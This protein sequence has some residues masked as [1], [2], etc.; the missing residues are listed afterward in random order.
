MQSSLSFLQFVPLAARPSRP[1][2]ARAPRRGPRARP[3]T[4]L[5]LLCSALAGSTCA[6]AGAHAQPATPS[7]TAKAASA[8]PPRNPAKALE[9][10]KELLH[11]SNYADAEANLRAALVGKHRAEAETRLAE[12]L[13]LTGRYDDALKAAKS[14]AKDKQFKAEATTYGAKALRHEGKLDEALALLE[15][16]EKEPE[17]RAARL[18]QGEIL[19][20]KGKRSEAEAP[21][22]TLIE[23][24][25]SD[26][27][28]ETD[29]AGLA[30]V[31]RAAHLLRAPQDANDAFNQ[32]ERAKTG[33]I[34]TLLW[35]AE[36]FL[37]KYDPGHAEEVIKEVLQQAPNHPEALVWMAHVKLA[38]ALDFDAAVRLVNQ[39]L[40]VNPKLGNAHFVLAGINLRDME[41][42]DADK[43]LDDGLK[44]NPRD[45]DLL[46]L[47]AAVRFL[48]DDDAGFQKA[49]RR[50]LKLN[51]QYSRMYQIIGE[52]A[53]WE[54]R[55]DEI[56][57][58]MR[59]ALKI[60]S[61]DAKAEAQ[62]GLNLI[63]AGDDAAG[64]K[65]LQSAFD[66]DGF[67]VRVY[68]TL[69]LYEKTI[70][71]EYVTV[72]E[73][74]Y[75]FRYHKDERAILE[76][77]IPGLM[78]DAWKAMVKYYGFTPS[79]PIGVELYADR[80]DFAIRTSGLPGTAIQGVCFGKTLASMSPKNETF[81]VGMTVWHELAHVFH[82]QMSKSHVPR[83]FTEGMAEYET[84]VAR[85]EWQREQDQDLYSA[86][87]DDRLP[88]LGNMNKAFTRA[89]E[90]SDIA[91]AYYASSQI[92][93][94]LG[95]KYGRAKLNQM[96]ELW[97]E[98]K[99][100]PEVLK[101]AL[102]KD[103]TELDRE[104][105]AFTSKLLGRYKKQFMPI[106]RT[107]PFEA[108]EE[109]ATKDPKSA[110]AQTTYAL[111]L[112][113]HGKAKQ[114]E[115]TLAAALKI[116]PKFPDAIYI[117]ARIAMAKR[118]AR[119]AK[120]LLEQL[121]ADGNDGY[122]VRMALADLAEGTGDVA[123]MKAELQ[124]AHRLDP[125]MAE[126][127]QALVDLAS[128]QKDHAAELDALKK[129]AKL[130]QHDPRVY[131][132]LMERL[133]EK[134]QLAEARAAGEAATWAD[135]EGMDTHRVFGEV[136][137]ASK[138]VPRAI[139]EGQSALLCPG[140]PKDQAKVHDLL[141]RAYAAVPNPKQ[142]AKHRKLAKSVL[143]EAS[144]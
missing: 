71:T 13:V 7:K 125:S 140:R 116:D 45:L 91:T 128:K 50:V 46:S 51:P 18:L 63:R 29:A 108:A 106:T 112:L 107:G 58:M 60:D 138:M 109:A 59:E 65:A 8:K 134:K 77:Y 73:G 27:I 40:K 142:A 21:L 2:V 69:N 95:E 67:N 28:T 132:R 86:L 97:G 23:D 93:V 17:A 87:R 14:A 72:K 110:K 34:Q 76:R 42:A 118:D 52:Y 22:M 64:L 111:A 56:V 38:Q 113:R 57:A 39:A 61:E 35:R 54:H 26:K 82:I 99:R 48:A 44:F 136:L 121:I 20:E 127:L 89:E 66:K 4:S 92:L 98:G 101:Q 103:S 12:L 19:L 70:P 74:Q 126:P 129:L 102:G 90:L 119:G 131:R 144:K 139:F 10:G 130:E 55:Y 94:M 75:T 81:N 117:Q 16:V 141:A 24:Y 122:S 25:N 80:Q 115:A 79:Q 62:L 83:W 137:L 36:L 30:M 31:G 33:D 53:E 96:L 37:E 68:N 114:A 6:C 49:K 1:R 3:L 88:K 124:A 32:A 5:L 143:S 9:Q 84:I 47:K 104:F 105:A 100:T 15:T 43:H 135:V 78:R 133:L 120:R 41:L 11:K 123:G 85:P